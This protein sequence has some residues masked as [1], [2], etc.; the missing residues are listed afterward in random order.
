MDMRKL[1]PWNWLK[2]EDETTG[3]TLPVQQAVGKSSL[4]PAHSPFA[5]LHQDFDRMVDTMMSRFGSGFPG[6]WG[7]FSD[8]VLKP[9]LD[10]SASENDY[11]ISVEVPGVDRNDVSLEVVNDTLTIRGEKKQEKE[12]KDG[13]YYTVE[14]SYG[15]FQRV[16]NLPED[17]DQDTIEA[18]FKDGVLTITIPRREIP[19]SS[20][21]SIDIKPSA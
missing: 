18:G 2:K 10:I 12:N 16:L 8:Q 1:A 3:S 4:H 17:A 19:R 11:T 13:G 21:R 9:T 14:R 5:Q 7:N 20:A 15:S 6:E